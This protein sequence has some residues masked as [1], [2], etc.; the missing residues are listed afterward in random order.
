MPSL[1]L[2]KDSTE[3]ERDVSKVVQWVEELASQ[4]GDVSSTRRAKGENQLLRVVL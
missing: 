2:T 3:K 4:P 1:S